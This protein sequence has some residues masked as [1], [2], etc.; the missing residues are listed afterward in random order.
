MDDAAS[1]DVA[2][3]EDQDTGVD[4]APETVVT[5][6]L[7]VTDFSSYPEVDSEDTT[8]INLDV[9]NI[10]DKDAENILVNLYQHD[11]FTPEDGD[12][13]RTHETL[14]APDEDIP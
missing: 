3:E 13:T 8:D 9:K 14:S 7:I 2:G 4:L 5:H 11:D 1:V 6:G 12:W 10:G